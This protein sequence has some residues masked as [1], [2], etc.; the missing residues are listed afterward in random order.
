[1]SRVIFAFLLAV[2][3]ACSDSFTDSRDGSTYNVVRIGNLMWMAENLAYESDGSFCPDGD[4]KNCPKYGRLYTWDAARGACPEGWR[5]P[6]KKDFE[7][8]IE[9]AGGASVAGDAL[10]S[11]SGWF[12]KGNGSDAFGFRALPAG[13]RSAGIEPDTPAKY[14][15]IGGYTYFWSVTEDEDGLV[16]YLFL[17]FSGKGASLNAFGKDAARSVR[18]VSEPQAE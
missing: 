9:A 14:G 15:G 18:C 8:L 11:G 3:A 7:S 16:Y 6:G 4:V 17:D 1:M 10:K 5:L 12:K 2:L 13:Y